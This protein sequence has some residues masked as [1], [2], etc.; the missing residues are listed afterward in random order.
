M[1]EQ[2]PDFESE[3]INAAN[4]IAVRAYQAYDPLIRLFTD[5]FRSDGVYAVK[6]RQKNAHDIADKVVRKRKT[7]P[8]Y[9]VSDVNDVI[10]IRF[11][12]LFQASIPEVL[13]NLL[14]F[15]LEQDGE[16]VIGKQAIQ[17]IEPYSNRHENA[18]L[19]IDNHV[20]LVLNRFGL[21]KKLVPKKP[22]RSGYSSVHV[23]IK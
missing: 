8:T 17:D 12:T 3:L 18:P 9:E 11:V 14:D 23:V 16:I 5:R 10:G 15:I 2:V 1:D 19:S 6:H 4:E 13:S 7:D 20:R 22:S 21:G